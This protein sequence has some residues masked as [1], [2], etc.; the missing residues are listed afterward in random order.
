MLSGQLAVITF[1]HSC[2]LKY[3]PLPWLCI[4]GFGKMKLRSCCSLVVS[5]LSSPTRLQFLSTKQPTCS[6]RPHPQACS[7]KLFILFSSTMHSSPT[8]VLNCDHFV[9]WCSCSSAPRAW[10]CH[11]VKM[12][13]LAGVELCL[14]CDL[15]LCLFPEDGW[16]PMIWAKKDG[17]QWEP[18]RV[19]IRVYYKLC[20]F[21]WAI[22]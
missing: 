5:F 18:W 10:T 12:I 21:V 6:R 17:V 1:F 14:L 8:Q 16:R 19:G 22:L 9:I 15:P 4:K 7:E 2:T 13:L 20:Y 3:C 11:F